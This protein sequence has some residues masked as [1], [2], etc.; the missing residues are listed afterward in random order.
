MLQK[1]QIFRAV[2]A[3]RLLTGSFM[4]S[5]QMFGAEGASETPASQ[6]ERNWQNNS[7]KYTAQPAPARAASANKA[8]QNGSRSSVNTVPVLKPTLDGVRRGTVS[9]GEVVSS[10][11]G[12]RLVD[13]SSIF[14]YYSNFSVHKGLAGGIMCDVRFIVMS[15]LDRKLNNLSVKLKWPGM[16]TAL[17]F[18][19]VA[20]NVENY[21]YYTLVGDGC[22][23]MDKIPNVI[24]NRCRVSRMTQQEC[25]SKIRWLKKQ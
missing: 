11:Q 6:G 15:T 10:D 18:N 4:A 20:P 19:D 7:Q 23:T 25:A 3:V 24:V 14:L 16:E 5:A 2:S 9:M 22:Y 12:M 13:T 21:F 17:N 1:K 8:N